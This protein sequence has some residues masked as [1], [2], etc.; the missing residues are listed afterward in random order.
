MSRHTPH[1]I[2]A[3]TAIIHK[4]KKD[5]IHERYFVLYSFIAPFAIKDSPIQTSCLKISKRCSGLL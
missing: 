5:K 3:V 2:Q 1:K 4:R